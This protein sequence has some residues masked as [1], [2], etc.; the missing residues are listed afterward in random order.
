VLPSRFGHCAAPGFAEVLAEHAER[1]R[2]N[3]TR[4]IPTGGP[5]YR[6]R[7]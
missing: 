7:F 5:M 4:S 6:M 1:S 2:C 3:S